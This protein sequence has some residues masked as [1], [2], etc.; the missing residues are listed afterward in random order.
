MT[1][2]LTAGP[3]GVRVARLPLRFVGSTPARSPAVLTP[4]MAL[5]RTPAATNACCCLSA[6]SGIQPYII[7]IVGDSGAPGYGMP[8]C[9]ATTE[10]PVQDRV[11]RST[12]K[13][14]KSKALLRV[15]ASA[16]QIDGADEV[17][18]MGWGRERAGAG[19]RV[20][21]GWQRMCSATPAVA[22]EKRATHCDDHGPSLHH[23]CQLI[24]NVRRAATRHKQ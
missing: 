22:A 24:I 8:C 2:P 21:I 17:Q 3:R 16:E 13:P 11:D 15:G 6:A 18:D 23:V 1:G 20:I 12:Q 9:R 19:A 4:D 14:L 10:R 7:E 5:R